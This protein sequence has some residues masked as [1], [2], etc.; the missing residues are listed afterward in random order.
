MEDFKAIY[1]AAHLAG[2]EAAATCDQQMVRAEN[3]FTGEVS[4]AFPI[5]GFAWIKFKGNTAWARWTKKAGLASKD[6]GGG[7]SIWV[8]MFGQSYDKK[9]AYA[10]A[11]S[12]VLEE[13][14]IWSY[15]GSRLD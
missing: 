9:R 15:A 12:K 14:G 6:Y 1:E 11:F 10:Q 4:E 3:V 5:C 7:Y 13:H 8:S 2:M